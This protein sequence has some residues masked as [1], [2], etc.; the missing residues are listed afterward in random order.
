MAHIITKEFITE[1]NIKNGI[2][3]DSKIYNHDS[4]NI[5][6]DSVFRNSDCIEDKIKSIHVPE[7]GWKK[8]S[9]AWSELWNRA[10]DLQKIIKKNAKIKRE[11]K[12][13]NIIHMPP[14][15]QNFWDLM[16][17]DITRL[18]MTGTDL[19]SFFATVIQND[20]FDDPT[21]IQMLYEY[22]A[23]FL[24]FSGTGDKVKQIYTQLGAQDSVTFN[25]WGIG[26]ER[27]LYS[28]LFDKIFD[29]QKINRAIARGYI[30][31]KNDRVIYPILNFVFPAT[32][33]VTAY[34]SGDSVEDNYYTTFVNALRVIA[35]LYD[36]Q[37]EK[38]INTLGGLSVACNSLKTDIISMVTSGRLQNGSDLR[39]LEPLSKIRR[40]IPYDGDK[41]PYLPDPIEFDG[42]DENVAYL[43]V[44]G[45]PKWYLLKRDLTS[46]AWAGESFSFSS[47]RNASYFVD[48]RYDEEFL[49]GA[50]G[51]GGSGP[52]EEDPE[53][54]GFIVKI[55]LPSDIAS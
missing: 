55:N 16:R 30:A 53:R 3:R 12:K 44:N 28:Q 11:G 48:S 5:N 34:S 9:K 8:N 22:G 29:A 10:E 24:P 4:G 26:W 27:D 51:S 31:R 7:T 43:F 36:P 13:I 35:K 54:Q 45:A 20:G 40:I 25:F 49:G 37:T 19:S 33:I 18:V 32:K 15:A 47:D 1:Q 52:E 46:Q 21:K 6:K 50:D 39:N 41:I 17:I 2:L 23:P 38:H 14:E 42:I